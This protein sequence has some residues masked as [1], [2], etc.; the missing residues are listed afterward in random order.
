MPLQILIPSILFP[1]AYTDLPR[2]WTPLR[3]AR[4]QG[5]LDME[6]M[7]ASSVARMTTKFASRGFVIEDSKDSGRRVS[8]SQELFKRANGGDGWVPF[9]ERIAQDLALCD[10]G[11]FI[12]LR[13]DGEQAEQI[14]V[15]ESV[16]DSAG[17]V[18]QG[19]TDVVISSGAKD[20]KVNAIY[21]LDSLRCTRT[22]NLAYPVRYMSVHG[23]WQLLRWDQVLVFA[24]QPSPRA[25]MFG[26]GR[27]AASRA[28]QTIAKLGAMEQMVYEFL[29]SNGA[30]KIAFLQGISSATL[31]SMVAT[32]E[33]NAR[34]RGLQYYKGVIFGAIPGDSPLS[35]VELVLKQLAPGFDPKT[36][37]DNAYIIYANALGIPVQD[38]QPLSGQGLGTGTQTE[39]LQE[40]AQG[41]G[42]AAFLKWW[43]QTVSDRILPE[44]TSFEFVNEHD[45]RDQKA[46]AEVKKLRAE[47]R[48]VRIDSGEISSAVARQLAADDGDLPQELLTTDVTP[49]DQLSD[50]EKP[51]DIESS[52]A[53]R[54]LAAG[55]PDAPPP[56]AQP[57]A[58]P[59]MLA[60]KTWDTATPLLIDPEL[61]D[62]LTWL[63][64]D[65]GQ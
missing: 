52:P 31:E 10:N 46:H 53:S 12:R 11:V 22:G 27:S 56:K 43:E 55:M 8:A 36:E 54:L 7:W 37:R 4:L 29:T 6:S 50:V 32:G 9:A 58:A 64:L 59:T 49:G 63:G 57:P 15:K 39:V 1:P 24:D 25:E 40:A 62:A 60:A 19:F 65:D 17:R 21:H 42:V 34:A 48:K 2:W 14:K 3:D 28:Y 30:N 23:V 44:T 51:T 47:E 5:T 13:R 41:I 61:A 33:E 26:V 20:G 45:M 38:I 16:V 18:K 35:L